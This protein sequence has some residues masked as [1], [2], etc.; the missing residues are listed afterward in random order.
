MHLSNRP[1][2]LCLL[3][4]IC[5]FLTADS[6]AAALFPIEIVSIS[7]AG[8]QGD[9]RSGYFSN[10]VSADG[11]YVVFA[12]EARDLVDGEEPE[13]VFNTWDLFLRDR[14]NKTTELVNLSSTGLRGNANGSAQP[15]IS[16]DGRFVAF[17]SVS[18][19]LAPGDP[20][21]SNDIYV[22]DRLTA[23]T[24]LISISS[25]G[26]KS[27]GQSVYPSISADGR[28]VAFQSSATNLVSGDTND[29]DDIFV[30][31]RL[32]R[33]TQR[34]S[35]SSAADQGNAASTSPALSADGRFVAFESLASNLTLDDDKLC[36]DA[37]NI[38]CQDVFVRDLAN[39]TTEIASLSSSGSNSDGDSYYPAISATGRFIAFHSLA[40]NFIPGDTNLCRLIYNCSDVYLRDRQTGTTE[41]ISRSSS[42]IQ[43]NSASVNPAISANGRYVVF[44]TYATNLVAGDSNSYI[45]VVV[46][47]RLLDI[48]ELISQSVGGL[49]TDD[50]SE[51]PSISAD[52]S[53]IVFN[54]DA[55]NLV[56]NDI[57]A[58]KDV[59][60]VVNPLYVPPDFSQRPARNY[61]TEL[62]IT[63]N[64]TRVSWAIGYELQVD[65]STAFNQPLVFTAMVGN[66]V[67]ELTID[68]L[69]SGIYFWRV[70]A[71]AP[72]T[73]LSSWALFDS[74]TIALE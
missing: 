3:V 1:L 13:D 2:L 58:G 57:R 32:T 49:P 5:Y 60:A 59:F 51:Y 18:N 44:E 15:S 62:P 24:E 20:D 30:R 41:L 31:D 73:F 36:D 17:A 23:T 27:N 74:F 34:V 71:I 25:A 45:D 4:C 11:R 29:Y 28:Y 21:D 37:R 19:N 40:N 35:I 67:L 48:T 43:G 50:H 69:P 66:G 56:P 72:F 65:T 52:G 64:W 55:E 68:N 46:R 54:S 12:S 61:F 7:S 10:A 42:N 22:R 6:F 33:T 63:L 14:L 39:A 53:L 16:A 47:D 9:D 26:I 8:V 38:T 70:R